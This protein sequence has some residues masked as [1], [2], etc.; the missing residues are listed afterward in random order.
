M[1][2]TKRQ[3]RRIIK[4]EKMKLLKEQPLFD[5]GSDVASD[6]QIAKVAAKLGSML[7][8]YPYRATAISDA[9]KEVDLPEAAD[10]LMKSFRSAQSYLDNV[11]S[12]Y[13]D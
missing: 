2:I 1:R 12:D 9:M 6:N 4:E 8:G 7:G 5:T 11:Y 10:A 3:L 13:D